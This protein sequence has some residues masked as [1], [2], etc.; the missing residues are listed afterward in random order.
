MTRDYELHSYNVK[1]MARAETADNNG[2][3]VSAGVQSQATFDASMLSAAYERA[4]KIRRFKEQ[5]ELQ[6]RIEAQASFLDAAKREHVDE[7]VRR[8]FYLATL[9]FWINQSLDE[10]KTI[11]GEFFFVTQWVVGFG[12]DVNRSNKN[13]FN[14]YYKIDAHGHHL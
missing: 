10:I 14:P 7:E 12:E 11:G 5:K 2:K 4:E 13:V 9:K 6:K 3:A 8:A 1:Q